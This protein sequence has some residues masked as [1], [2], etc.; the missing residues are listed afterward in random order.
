MKSFVAL[1]NFR[2]RLEAETV[3]GLLEGAD[4]TF[5]IQSLEG[6][7]IVPGPRGATIMVRPED[8]EKSKVVID[9]DQE[10][11]DA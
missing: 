8:L 4:V 3:A 11:P 6:A 7:G 2:T 5:L 1:A 9:V 10:R